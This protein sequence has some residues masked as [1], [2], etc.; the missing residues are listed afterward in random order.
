LLEQWRRF[1]H[2]FEVHEQYRQPDA[3]NAAPGGDLKDEPY[4]TLARD[5]GAWGVLSKDKHFDDPAVA[6]LSHEHTSAFRDYARYEATSLYLRV[7]GFV[8][9]ELTIQSVIDLIGSLVA[10]W[11][12][13]PLAA[14]VA[15]G[16]LAG[17]AVA[18]PS[19]RSY[20][21]A[22]LEVAGRTAGKG[23][24]QVYHLEAGLRREADERRLELS[25]G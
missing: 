21:V 19:A 1:A 16:A 24:Q 6:Q 17:V 7:G 2:L 14:Q 9:M 4:A 13:L 12:G 8:V 11:R 25:V 20:L 15:V 22:A 3:S 18:N 23:A 5:I 10:L